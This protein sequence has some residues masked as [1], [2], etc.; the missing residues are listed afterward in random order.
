MK[1]IIFAALAASVLAG[2]AV[3]SEDTVTLYHPLGQGLPSIELSG[4]YKHIGQGYH[5][6]HG[7]GFAVVKNFGVEGKPRFSYNSNLPLK[8]DSD[9][10]GYRFYTYGQTNKLKLEG[11]YKGEYQGEEVRIGHFIEEGWDVRSWKSYKQNVSGDRT[12]DV[13]HSN[14]DVKGYWK[15]TGNHFYFIHK[16]R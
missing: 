7:G 8:V 2:A 5:F 15:P 14:D 12:Y 11:T 16:N 1:K 10:G 13:V 9:G 3:A 6:N 4:D